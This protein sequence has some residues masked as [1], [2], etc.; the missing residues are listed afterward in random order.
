MFYREG[1][2]SPHCDDDIDLEPDELGRDFGEA[3]GASFRRAILNRTCSS[4]RLGML[5]LEHIPRSGKQRWHVCDT[6]NLFSAEFLV[7]DH[8]LPVRG[9]TVG[10]DSQH[11]S[12]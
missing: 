10:P 1:R 4:L 5:T 2:R 9:A 12:S 6:K 11:G 7:T 8:G 3:F